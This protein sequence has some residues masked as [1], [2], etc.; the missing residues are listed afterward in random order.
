MSSPAA[1]NSYPRQLRP[2][3]P[4]PQISHVVFDFDGTLSWLRH[5]WPEIMLNLF[6]EYFPIH[7]GDDLNAIKRDLI[8]DILSLN[9][10]PTVF[11]MRSFAQRAIA[12]GGRPPRPEELL[13]EYQFRLDEVIDERTDRIKDG[14]AFP[15]HF[16]VFG[17]RAMLRRLAER[18]VTLY[19]LSGT[20]IERV[21]EEAALLQ[22]ADFF[23]DRIFGSPADATGFSKRMVFDR[24][25]AEEGIRGD[26]LLSF[27]DGP[28][29]IHHTAELGGIAVG[30]ASDE[31]ENGSGKCD[32][33]KEKQL[34]EAGAHLMM[35]DYRDPDAII[36][37]L[38]GVPPTIA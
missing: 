8:N 32:P 9:G 22:V 37:R 36:D 14:S 31:D 34:T 3:A 23:E 12:R 17:G 27:G 25:L 29:E 35:A 2:F 5:G 4:R 6:L 19:I 28:V 10:Q 33:W 38:F 30:V 15:D 1:P 13:V 16:V 20:H 18:D 21:L 26:Q 24:I 7:P 11:Q